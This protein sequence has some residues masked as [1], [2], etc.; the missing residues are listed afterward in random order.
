[1]NIVEPYSQKVKRQAVRGRRAGAAIG[2]IAYGIALVA[3]VGTP[4]SLF[5][6]SIV[7][8]GLVLFGGLFA[9]GVV[10]ALVG[11]AVTGGWSA[12]FEAP[13]LKKDEPPLV[14]SEDLGMKHEVK[15]AGQDHVAYV[16]E[17]R[18]VEGSKG[19]IKAIDSYRDFVDKVQN[20]PSDMHETQR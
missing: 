16:Y 4:A 15:L 8:N 13:S 7:L 5:G 6:A 17:G 20:A 19:K 1:M 12:V 18:V 14:P 11:S 9:A 3:T 10:G 2:A